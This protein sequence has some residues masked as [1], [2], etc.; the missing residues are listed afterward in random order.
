MISIRIYKD[1]PLGGKSM[2]YC[3]E[4]KKNYPIVTSTKGSSRRVPATTERYSSRGDYIG[5]EEGET[6]AVNI[7]TRPRCSNCYSVFEFPNITSQEEFFDVKRNNLLE[8]WRRREPSKPVK[9]ELGNVILGAVIIGGVV[10]VFTGVLTTEATIQ[11]LV[12]AGVGFGY[13]YLM[14]NEHRKDLKKYPEDLKKYEDEIARWNKKLNE[15]KSLT[16]SDENYERLIRPQLSKEAVE[17]HKEV[18]RRIKLGKAGKD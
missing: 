8:I 6:Y 11:F 16:Y 17:K 18:W 4:C 13:Y 3:P 14:R 12:S 7:E 9:P 10:G 2:A 5:Y 15:L 1:I